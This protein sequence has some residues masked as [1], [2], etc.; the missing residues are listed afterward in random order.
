MKQD[1]TI[2]SKIGRDDHQTLMSNNKARSEYEKN[3]V[4]LCVLR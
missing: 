4:I 1:V 2:A 3:N